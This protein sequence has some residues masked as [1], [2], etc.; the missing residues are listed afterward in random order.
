MTLIQI[1]M[2]ASF[3]VPF[4]W[5]IP[6]SW[7]TWGLMFGSILAI[8]WLQQ[9]DSFQGLEVA[10]PTATIL[11][12]VLVWWLVQPADALLKQ[13]KETQ[14]AIL[15]MSA[16]LLVL[17]IAE[18]LQ[19]GQFSIGTL[20][21]FAAFLITSGMS[22]T[23]LLPTRSENITVYKQVAAL[24]VAGIIGILIILKVPAIA[25]ALGQ[26]FSRSPSVASPLVWLGFSYVA[27]RLMAILL[28]FRAGRLPKEGIPLQD[29]ASYVLFFP[30][31]TAG[32]IDRTQRFLPELNKHLP[33]DAPR[34]VDG[35]GRISIGIF[36]KFVVADSL[37][38]VALNSSLAEQ[39]Q[40]TWGLWLI[41]YLYAFQIFFD[42]SGYSDVAIGMGRLY[43]FQ[44]PENFDRPYTQSNL[45]QF[46][47]RWH[48]TLS[49]WFRLYFFTPFSRLL[50]QSRLKPFQYTIILIAQ[51]STMVLIG[52]WHG[53]T[54]N[55]ILWGVWHGMGLFLLRVIGD[56]SKG[57]YRWTQKRNWTKRLVYIGSIVTTF[58]YVAL[59]WVFFALPTPHASFDVLQRLFGG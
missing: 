53:V 33:L 23:Q 42:F 14:K 11:L 58:H 13:Q 6:P 18:A 49:T 45:Q 5:L 39:T 32:P 59:G 7:R 41:V 2:L 25:T 44:L 52:L 19:H 21:V 47:Q 9:G 43:G 22:L 57:W 56:Y 24:L 4:M 8:G 51:V 48:M 34:M 50:I 27:F 36:K 46:W 55:F 28:D 37:A 15:I 31:Y 26:T 35:I 20:L 16:A 40:T 29:M 54:L 30:A 1:L 17:F 10:L 3:A 12:T 38:R